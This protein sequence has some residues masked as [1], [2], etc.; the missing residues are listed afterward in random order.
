MNKRK[1]IKDNNQII[2]AKKR[3]Q[4]GA[5]Y[6]KYRAASLDNPL[7]DFEAWIDTDPKV[8]TIGPKTS[9]S[10]WDIEQGFIFSIYWGDSERGS[11]NSIQS[12]QAWIDLKNIN[13]NKLWND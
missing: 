6:K 2:L 9:Q 5:E 4:F 12:A 3:V 8:W 1:F 10:N 13:K 11:F 7:L